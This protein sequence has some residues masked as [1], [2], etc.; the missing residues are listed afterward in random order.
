MAIKAKSDALVRTLVACFLL[1]C[2]AF[3]G[4]FIKVAID[5]SGDAWGVLARSYRAYLRDTPGVLVV[6]AAQS[7]DVLLE[8]V[9]VVMKNEGGA[10]TGYAW[11][12]V[13]VEPTTKAE[14]YGPGVIVCG[15][16]SRNV[17][18]A[19]S[20]NVQGIERELLVPML[21]ARSPGGSQ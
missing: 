21:N 12:Y 11:A 9:C 1:V 17:A 5:S 7:P 16:S 6:S 14:V 8:I 4:P 20:S 19:V 10:D 18:E 15:P 3:A 13:G 2:P